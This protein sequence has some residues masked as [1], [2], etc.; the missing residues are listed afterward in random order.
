MTGTLDA[1]WACC[2]GYWRGAE[3]EVC[4]ECAAARAGDMR[5]APFHSSRNGR[6]QEAQ[7]V[8]GKP[9][10]SRGL[11]LGV[12]SFSRDGASGALQVAREGGEALCGPV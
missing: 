8:A 4:L 11:Q 9:R 5:M 12:A 1:L 7:G 6:P 10:W 2:R 3:L